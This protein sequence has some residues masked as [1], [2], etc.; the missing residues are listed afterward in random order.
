MPFSFKTVGLS[1]LPGV[2]PSE[3][4]RALM[5]HARN[6]DSDSVEFGNS[7]LSEA[8]EYLSSHSLR[9]LIRD[10]L[11]CDV[12]KAEIRENKKVF[13]RLS[14]LLPSIAE[15]FD[16]EDPDNITG[17]ISAVWECVV[18]YRYSL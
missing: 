2:L 17:L 9:S 16:P 10:E 1:A 4:L 5:L 6:V 13:R 15:L 7:L 11:P 3:V 12:A 18:D 14:G 8:G